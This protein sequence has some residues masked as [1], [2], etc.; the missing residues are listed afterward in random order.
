MA[1]INRAAKEVSVK[2]VYYGPGLCGK[3]TN[4]QHIFD[5]ANPERR[6]KLLSVATET[7]RTLFFDFLPI[8]LGTIRGMKLKVGLYTVP[9]Q[10]FYDATRR[11][12]L[13]GADGVVFV[14]DSQAPMIDNNLESLDN[15]KTN[16]SLNN[17]DSE[18]IPLVIQFN[19]RD[20]PNAMSEADLNEALNWRKVPTTT[21]VASKGLGVL[22]TLKE[23][24]KQVI[25]SLN[26]KV[27]TASGS[28]SAAAKSAAPAAGGATGSETAAFPVMP[29][30]AQTTAPTAAPTVEAMDPADAPPDISEAP[31][32]AD[33]PMDEL[34]PAPAPLIVAPPPPPPPPAPSPAPVSLSDTGPIKFKPPV[35]PAPPTPPRFV[36]DAL[37]PPAAPAPRFVTD[38][39]PPPPAAPAMDTTQAQK[40]L[41]MLES[42]L[43]ALESIIGEMKTEIVVLKKTIG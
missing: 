29:R 22:D 8:D 38:A 19:K 14:A 1:T 15:L 26:D 25:A 23:I 43:A 17:L 40:R 35:E 20:L 2:V 16:L 6:G 33:V 18:A 32:L 30:A 28:V 42:H 9:G 27:E 13:R 4:L 41:Q 11:L 37:P 5:T 31:I 21:A 3:T 39:V 10:V 24:V 12:V 7:D 36:T 34:P